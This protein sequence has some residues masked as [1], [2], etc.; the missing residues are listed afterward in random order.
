MSP[1]LP[2]ATKVSILLVEDNP[3]DARLTRALLA[4]VASFEFELEH[5][6]K[7]ADAVATLQQRR[8]DVILL[9]LSLPDS[10]GVE[11][12]SALQRLAA[13]TP[14]V[15]LTGRSDDAVAI[16]V[17]QAG[18]ED[19]LIK[20]MGDGQLMVRAIR[21]SIE[22]A[23]ARQ[24]LLEAKTKAEIA[25][26][27]KTEFL[28][29]MSHELR[30][31]LNAIMGFSE[32]MKA[33]MLGPIG[34]PTYVDYARDIHQSAA[35]LLQIINDILDL[36]K[37]EAGKIELDEQPIDMHAL[38]DTSLRLVGERAHEAG[39]TVVNE[40]P[41]DLPQLFADERLLKQILINL[42]SN[43]IKFTDRGGSVRIQA[44]REPT[45]VIA[46]SVVDTGIGI[47]EEDLPK[48]MEPFRQADSALSRKYEGTGL[49][50]PLVKSFVELH[51]GVFELRSQLGVGTTATMRFP[52]DRV[53]GEGSAAAD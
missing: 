26:R 9:D 12:I 35:H 23:R 29:N 6:P 5:V 37:V 1:I 24:L 49:G 41:P 2:D 45:G 21:Y 46:I 34:N 52:R 39:V 32:L 47:S 14:I 8:V 13:T 16:D 43:S 44:R 20:G 31:P 10:H 18:A 11:G 19:Y 25:N 4:E 33:Q 38:V 48:V 40:V 50:L 51:R 17:L 7:L 28:A 3:G 53:L 15:V 30:T 27:T 36:S 22:R 42:L